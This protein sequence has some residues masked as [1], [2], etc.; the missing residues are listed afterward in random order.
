[1]RFAVSLALCT[2]AFAPV[3]CGDGATPADASDAGVDVPTVADVADDTA[4]AAVRVVGPAGGTVDRFRF[5]VFG[6][7]RPPNEDNT[8]AY[9]T[10]IVTSVMTGMQGAN[11]QFAVATGDYMY[12]RSEAVANA[13]LDLLMGA[14]RLYSPFIF[15]A[16][17]NHECTGAT[18]SNCPNANETGNIRVFR[19]RLQAELPAVY[20]DWV[21]H[22]SNGD[23][24]FIVTA[25]NAWNASQEAW[26]MR[27]LGQPARYT[28]V[29]AHEPPT[30]DMGPGSG[31]IESAIRTRAGG[32]TL[33]MYGHS[34]D[35]RRIATNAIISGN[36]G[37]PLTGGGTFGYAIVEQRADGNV[38][39][40]AYNVGRPPMLAETFAVQPDG[41][42][43]R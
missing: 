8:A 17:G 23:A 29:I 25:P 22:T 5:A 2:L 28:F 11:T 34:H 30:S 24:H 40:E 4:D 6:D 10:A 27:V 19:A 33:R 15:H 7:V 39:V 14:E 38:N 32:V 13:Q 18:A 3:S 12:A 1:M 9:P 20:F 37:A 43:A 35:F 31:A 21:V 36:A 42:M 26:L 16:H 41:T